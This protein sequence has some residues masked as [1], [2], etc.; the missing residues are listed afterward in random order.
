MNTHKN[1][2]DSELQGVTLSVRCCASS[3]C[4]V[5]YVNL[6][7][8]PQKNKLIKNKASSQ[9]PYKGNSTEILYS[10][11]HNSVWNKEQNDAQLLQSE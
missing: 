3:F 11:N 2:V 5:L 6:P 4:S 9:Q 7:P 10:T 8:D 1:L